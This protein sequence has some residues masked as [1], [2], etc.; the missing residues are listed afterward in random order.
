MIVTPKK[1][2]SSYRDLTFGQPY[3]VIGIEA[4]DF[5]ILNDAGRPFLYPPELFT[6]VDKSEPNDW[7]TE[8]GEDHERYS[9]PPSLNKAGFFEDFFDEKRKAVVTFWR[10]VNQRLAGSQRRVA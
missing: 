6:M 1:K 3:V 10:V 4:D 5:R 7:V 9:Y 8:F 2:S